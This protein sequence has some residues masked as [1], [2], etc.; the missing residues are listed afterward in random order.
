[1]S[2]S[3]IPTPE[4][5]IEIRQT[6]CGVC[7]SQMYCG[8]DAYVKDGKIIKVEGTADHPQNKGKLCV[9]GNALKDYVYSPNRIKTPLKRVGPRGS[10]QFEAIS[11]EEAW[12]ILG[13]NCKEIR[14]NYGPE[15]L[16]FFVGYEKWFR[17]F[18]H[19]LANAWGTPNYA[20]ESS[21]CASSVK[22][23]W[24]LNAGI[25]GRPDTKNCKSYLGF[26]F[27][28]YYSRFTE[29][30]NMDTL[31]DR[32]VKFIIIDPRETP[33]VRRS[34]ALHLQNI[35]G[36]DGAIALCL[37]HQF[38]QNG[39]ADMDYI[40]KHV[41][42]FAEFAEYVKE[43]TPEHT[44]EISGVS[45]ADLV[46]AANIL[47]ENRPFA[48]HES[49][50]PIVHHRNGMQNYR[51]MTALSAIAGCYD[52]EGGT[53]PR[54]VTYATQAAGFTTLEAAFMNAG[55]K[56]DFSK[57]HYIGY[58][59][60]PLRHTF[61]DEGQMMG[62]HR[63]VMEGTPYPIA[64]LIGFGH[65]IRIMPDPDAMVEAIKKLDF[66]CVVDLFQ[67]EAA[68]LADLVLPACTSVERDEFK[69]YSGGM[70]HYTKRAIDPIYESKPDVEIISEMA[71]ALEVNDPLLYAGYDACLESILG[72]LSVTLDQL[73]SSRLPVPVPEAKP[74]IP[75][76]YTAQGY[77]TPTGKFELWSTIIDQ[78]P[79]SLNLD[80]LPTYRDSCDNADPEKY[81]LV[82]FTGSSLP[83]ALHSR[84][85]HI[86]SLR[87]FRK[88]PAADI[89]LVDAEALGIA[90]DDTIGLYTTAGEIIVKANLTPTIRPGTVSMYH[91]YK[92]ADVN[93]IIP[94][95]HCDPYS[96]FPGY[97]SIRC[98]MRRV[99]E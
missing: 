4:S 50:S 83:H 67:T 13:K 53:L 16:T 73:K 77:K 44:E 78:L 41:H 20:T 39:W 69:V 62:F 93:T 82:L 71:K 55:R 18:L 89:S 45:A 38:I 70:A 9:K 22:I 2:V 75:G 76:T 26:S 30:L 33:T 37:C 46:K 11:W 91:G 31:F 32:D 48:I 42:G 68:D 21:T 29:G 97:K 47:A 25:Q 54:P 94:M 12:E 40:D 59:E 74:Y 66:Y 90:Q 17:P 49:V 80:P 60:F 84:T 51:A 15:G 88:E 58:D 99:E 34:N 3:K 86:A 1:M 36:T 92:E 10:G 7:C 35:P 14:K 79:K 87:Q 23:A 5:G 65:N 27:N 96:G 56:E 63:Q 95:S 85:H 8:V 6:F 57:A 24:G 72:N 28:Q 61:L 64:G 43:F 19:R 52:V 98:G 81:P